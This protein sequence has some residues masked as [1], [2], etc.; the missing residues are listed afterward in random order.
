MVDVGARELGCDVSDGTP[1]DGIHE[2]LLLEKGALVIGA[3]ASV[4]EGKD[5]RE[6]LAH[7]ICSPVL[8]ADLIVWRFWPCALITALINVRCIGKSILLG[9]PGKE[10]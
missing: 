7:Q 1:E 9:N 6:L 2:V 3:F 10:A 5:A 4:V 8:P